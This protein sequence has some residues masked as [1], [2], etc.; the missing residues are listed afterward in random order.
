MVANK[1]NWVDVNVKAEL[2]RNFFYM[3]LFLNTDDV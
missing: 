3:L 1:F 2:K